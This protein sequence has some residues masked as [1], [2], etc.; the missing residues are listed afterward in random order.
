[1]IGKARFGKTIKHFFSLTLILWATVIAAPGQA[2]ILFSP[3]HENIVYQGRW[4]RR[5]PQKAITIYSG[6]IIRFAFTGAA[7]ALHFDDSPYPENLR[8]MLWYRVDEGAWRA[9]TVDS[10]LTISPEQPADSHPVEIITKSYVVSQ[11]RWYPPLAAV[12]IFTGVAL[13]DGAQ[14]LPGRP[15]SGPRV[16]VLADSITEGVAVYVN[17][18]SMNVAQVSDAKSSY[19]YLAA[20]HYD[21]DLRFTVLSGQGVMT[22]GNGGVPECRNTFAYIYNGVDNDNWQADMVIVNYGTND[23]ASTAKTYTAY[24]KFYIDLIRARYPRAEI[25]CLRPFNGIQAD[26]IQAA[27][28]N[29]RNQGDSAV[30]YVD[31][32]GWLDPANTTDG[33]HPT[34][35]SHALLAE[36]LME[37]MNPYFATTSI[38]DFSLY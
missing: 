15:A 19:A 6:A 9:R 22:G 37:I 14:L 12:I 35:S 30:H 38:P 27:V 28:E 1:M 17:D 11:N 20:M 23:G 10:Q 33:R 32:T 34:P 3:I 18:G 2:E 36:K 25:L 24:Y 7:C 31:T 21:A 4:D 29:V 13:E 8:P 26:A 5:D 16:E